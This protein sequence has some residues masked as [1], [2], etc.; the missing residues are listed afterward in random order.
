MTSIACQRILHATKPFRAR[1]HLIV[2]IN[3]GLM[4]M[5]HMLRIVTALLLGLASSGVAQTTARSEPA[6]MPSS[7]LDFSAID[8]FWPVV[9]LLRKDVEPS[10]AQ[11]KTLLDTP[12]YRLAQIALGEVVKE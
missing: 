1:S 5:A 7:G 8:A 2:E 11:W 10:D 6:P 9:D 3:T 12:G 4:Y